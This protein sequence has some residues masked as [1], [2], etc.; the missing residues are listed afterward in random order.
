MNYES[1]Q[2]TAQHSMLTT[3]KW[4]ERILNMAISVGEVALIYL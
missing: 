3:S 2:L 4:N 1:T